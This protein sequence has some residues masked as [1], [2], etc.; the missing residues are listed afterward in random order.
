MNIIKSCNVLFIKLKNSDL[1]EPAKLYV[2]FSMV[3]SVDL[4]KGKVTL[5]IQLQII[6]FDK[7]VSSGG[8]F[9]YSKCGEKAR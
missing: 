6:S 1:G 7:P 2:L 4:I 3:L 5:C 9:T 8:K